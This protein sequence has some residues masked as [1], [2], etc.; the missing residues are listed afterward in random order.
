[1]DDELRV[2]DEGLPALAAL[3]AFLPRVNLLMYDEV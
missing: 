1:M 2:L 3:V